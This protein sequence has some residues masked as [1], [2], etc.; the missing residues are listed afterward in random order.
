MTSSKEKKLIEFK[1]TRNEQL[2]LFELD[3]MLSAYSQSI[4]LYDAMPKYV[5]GGVEREK[6]KHVDALPVLQREFVNRN[7]GYKLNIYPG[8][9]LDKKTGKTIHYY[10]SQREELVEDVIKK[11]ATKPGRASL[12]DNEVGVKFTYYEVMQELKRIGHGYSL[13]E[14]KLAIDILN[15]SMLEP[16]SQDENE[17]SMSTPF[18]PFVG[19]ETK[20]MAGKERV[21]VVFHPLVTRSINFQTYRLLNFEKVMRMKMQLSRWLFKRI[22]HLF[23]QA[24]VNNP[25]R[26]KLST[27]IRD[28]GMKE[29]KTI[30]DRRRQVEKALNELKKF[31]VISEWV[32]ELDKEKNKILDVLYSLSMSEEFVADAKKANKITNLKLENGNEE[33]G[34]FDLEL[35]RKEI[36]RSIYGYTKT[37]INNFLLKIHTKD[38]YDVAVAALEAAKQY[39]MLKKSKGEQINAAAITKSAI[40]DGWVPKVDVEEF[41]ATKSPTDTKKELENLEDKKRKVG[42]MHK[43]LQTDPM[44]VEIRSKIQSKFVGEPWDKWLAHLEVFSIN[45]DTLVM[46][47]PTK[48]NRDWIIKEFIEKKKKSAEISLKEVVQEVVPIRKIAVIC[49]S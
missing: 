2:Q 29:Y 49:N 6:G 16:I 45:E 26:I 34:V 37:M 23:S 48:F 31:N 38:E 35:L 8:A 25:Y 42:E 12:F 10:P 28:S 30:Y 4:E 17:V 47:A 9:I 41:G 15:K 39:I 22:S 5:F 3:P 27:I 24:T 36:E 21:V 20:E 18:F 43:S 33:K 40:R 14:I 11:I 1:Q 44:W 19:K 32:A 7:K 46:L 13:D